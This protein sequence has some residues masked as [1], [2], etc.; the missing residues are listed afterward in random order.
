MISYEVTLQLQPELAAAIEDYMRRVHIPAI[1]A[2]GCFQEIRLSF[3]SPARFRTA[4]AAAEQAALDRYLSDH[5]AAF[6]AD[7]LERFPDG[8][9]VTRQTWVQREMWSAYVS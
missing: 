5:A 8:V 6:R 3:A 9:T 7:F 4:Y 1:L 2:T